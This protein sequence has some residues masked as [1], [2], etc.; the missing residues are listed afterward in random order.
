MLRSPDP[1]YTASAQAQANFR[2]AAKLALAFVAV[3]WLLQAANWA[4]DTPP[5]GI[6]PRTPAGLAGVLFAPVSHAGFGHLL[7]NS[8]PLAVLLTATMHLYPR[9][10]PVVLPLLY[11]G[12]GLAV[13][14]FGRDAVHAGAS[15]LVYG[16]V[17]Y[18][19]VAG[20]LRRDRRAIAASLAVAFLYGYTVWGVL[21]IRRHDS[22][23]THLAALLLGI[24]LALAMRRRDVPP[25]ATYAWEGGDDDG[26][27]EDDGRPGAADDA[28][29]APAD[30]VSTGAPPPR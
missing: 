30:D 22:W 14:A 11:V 18:V 21:P 29:P 10:S 20:L 3:L 7:A 12:P 23:E 16:L 9:A 6:A 1:A 15:G 25:A 13:W 4:L 5:L 19:F 17:A 28:P 27:S 8:L 2:L 24:A 26:V